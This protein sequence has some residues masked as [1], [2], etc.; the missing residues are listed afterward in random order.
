MNYGSAIANGKNYRHSKLPSP[1]R[2]IIPARQINR[3]ATTNSTQ[4]TAPS[5]PLPGQDRLLL[6]MA[7]GTGKTY[8]AF[9]IIWRLWKTGLKKRILFLADR[10]ILVDQART[11]DFKP[12]GAAL[13]KITESSG[14]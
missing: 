6:V 5:R 14:G 1:R 13:T 2:I 9:Q 10:N 4:S 3:P 12:F 8:V 7:T 11:N